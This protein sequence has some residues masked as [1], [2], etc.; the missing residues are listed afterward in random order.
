MKIIPIL[1]S[2]A[3]NIGIFAAAVSQG[4]DHFQRGMD[5]RRLGDMNTAINEFLAALKISDEGRIH[6]E[7]GAAY[8]VKS[9]GDEAIAELE[10]SLAKGDLDTDDRAKANYILAFAF[11]QQNKL[12]KA[13]ACITEALKERPGNFSYIQRYIQVCEEAVKQDPF[14]SLNH[15]DLGKARQQAGQFDLAKFEYTQ[16]LVFD[17]K[18]KNARALLEKLPEAQRAYDKEKSKR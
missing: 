14:S 15:L 8:L 9:R 10:K 16:S 13:K 6:Y 3:I 2:C 7:L 17:Q 4:E 5:A 18:N 12:T 11:M 1:L